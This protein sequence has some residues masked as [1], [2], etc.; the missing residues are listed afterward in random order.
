MNK[1]EYRKKN[2]TKNETKNGYT[3]GVNVKVINVPF[4]KNWLWLCVAVALSAFVP[5]L[6][7]SAVRHESPKKDD[8]ILFCQ[9]GGLLGLTCNNWGTLGG[10]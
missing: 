5:N 1:E 10:N 6:V 2:E 8:T 4:N 7:F 9:W 3:T